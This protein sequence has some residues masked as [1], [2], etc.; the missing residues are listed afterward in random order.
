MIFCKGKLSCINSFIKLFTRYAQAFGQ[1]VS[2]NKSTV[3]SFSIP[4]ARLETIVDVIGFQVGS[5]TFTYLGVPI[6]NGKPKARHFQPIADK[7]KSKISAWKAS[8][9]SIAGKVQLVKSI[10]QSMLIHTITVYDWHVSLIKDLEKAIRN[11]IWSGS[12]DKRKLVVVA[13]KKICKPTDQGEL[14]IRSLKKLN[15]AVNLKLCWDIF[16]KKEDWSILLLSRVMRKRR[17]ISH[18]ISSSIWSSIKSEFN[19]MMENSSWLLGDGSKIHFWTDNWCGTPLNI[20]LS[21]DE[22]VD[23]NILVSDY[24]HNN[25]WNLPDHF[26]VDFHEV[27]NHVQ[28]VTISLQHKEDELVW[29][30]TAS[31]NLT[32]K[33]AYNFIDVPSQHVHWAKS[34]WSP[35]IPPSKSLLAWRLMNDKIPVDDKLKQRGCVVTSA[36]TLCM[37]AE[38]S[39]FHLFFECSYAIHLWCWLASALNQSLHFSA[40]DEIWSLSERGWS[41]QR[42]LNVLFAVINILSAIWNARNTYRFKNKKIHWKSAIS[43]IIVDVSLSASNSNLAASSSIKEFSILK[44]FNVSIN[45]PKISVVKEVI[46]SPPIAGWIKCNCDRAFTAGKASCGAIFRNAKGQFLGCFAEGLHNGNSLFAEL[47]GAMRSIEFASSKSWKNFWLE[48]D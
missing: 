28:Q 4:H 25:S 40:L 5:L 20:Y 14:R 41:P 3:Y 15:Q 44:A 48:T 37:A 45:P 21:N 17:I 35:N 27:W 46:W 32:F 7:V 13:W 19:V 22:I 18:H 29:C 8:L 31:G 2:P 30:A 6:F 24:I 39:T 11:F 9:L 26:S 38:E 47:I 34:I 36:C 12:I 43:Q 16:H 23:D 1:I 42:R 33:Y 10:I